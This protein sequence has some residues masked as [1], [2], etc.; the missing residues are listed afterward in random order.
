MP[1]SLMHDL[2]RESER[3]ETPCGGG[4]LVWRRW[5]SG[6]PIVLMHGGSG[7]WTH[8][9]RN[10]PI[11]RQHYE[12]WAI[13]IPGL[14]DSAMP[15]EPF[16]PQSCA[17]AVALGFKRHFTPDRRARLV[18]FSFGC[19]VGTLAARELN[20][21]LN[22]MVIIGTAALGLN[23]SR[24]RPL[25]KERSSM[26][27]EERREIHRAVL[28][29]LMFSDAARIDDEAI[30]LQAV[31]I[32]NA[33]FRSREFAATEDVRHGLAKVTVPLSTIW[34]RGDVV[35]NPDVETAIAILAEHHPELRHRIIENAGHWVMY[36]QP[37]AFNTALLEFLGT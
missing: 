35:A 22:G 21:L 32:A 17:D 19:H 11:L 33:R 2:D 24:N 5:G 9:I 15:A 1:L 10:I 7:S 27:A 12:V 6:D 8:W 30:E 28:E 13:D 23:R 31:N 14:G 34:G 25:P 20:H 26:T 3:L 29:N 4:S 36:E 37:E 16:V 18:C